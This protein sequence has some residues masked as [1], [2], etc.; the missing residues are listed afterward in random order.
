MRNLN[1]KN[2]LLHLL[3]QGAT[4]ITPNNRLSNTLLQEYFAFSQNKTV[5]KPACYPYRTALIKAFEQLVF[6]NPYQNWPILL[7]K[8][9]CQHLWSKLIKSAPHITYSEGLLN[10]V[11]QAW[12]HCQ[13]WQINPDDPAFLYTPQTR[14]FQLWWQ[15]FNKQLNNSN[16]ISE[17]QILTYLLAADKQLFSRHLV[18]VCFDDFNPL[19]VRLQN[20]LNNHDVI[21][22]CYDLTAQSAT[23]S[24]LAAQDNKDEYQQLMLWL[25]ARLAKGDRRIGVVIPEL[26]QEFCFLQRTL[27]QHFALDL[28]DISLGQ[29][30]SRFPI[31]AHALVWINLDMQQLNHHQATL[32]LQ[33]PYL[34]YAKEEFISRSHHLQDSLLL[35]TQTCS[36]KRFCQDIQ[37]STPKL[38]ELLT[39]LTPYPDS[40]SLQQWIHI[41]QDRL[42]TLG[43]PGDYGLNSENYQCFNRFSTLFDEFRQLTVV[44][45]KLMRNEAIDAFTLLLNNTIFQAQ[46]MSAPIQISGLLEASGCE[47]DSLWVMGLTDQCLPQKPRLSAFI[48][49][50][51]QR[52]LLMPHSLPIRELQF[53]RQTLQRL[54]RA[55]SVT[56]FSYSRLQRDTPNLPCS[57]IACYPDFEPLPV[58]VNL[59]QDSCL[60]TLE[61]SYIVPPKTNERIAGGTAILANQAKCP[62]KAFAKHRLRAEPV[63]SLSDGIDN[64]EKGIIVHKVMELLWQELGSQKKLLDLEAHVLADYIEKA[65]QTALLPLQQHQSDVIPDLVQEVEQT[66]LKRVVQSCLEWEKQRPPF[67][68]A[69]IEHSYSIN[70]AGLDFSVRVDRLDQVEQTKWVI[71]Y[72][73]T[74]PGSKPWNEER[75]QEPQLLLYA[76]L[77]EHIN[78][79]L[80][81]QLKTGKIAC[82]GL[83]E[84]K[85][86]ISG[87]SAL[88]KDETWD[89]SR[90]KWRQQLT[91]LAEEIQAGYCAPQPLSAAICQQCDFQN[92][93]RY[94]VS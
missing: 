73:S 91:L 68:I 85:Q 90:A 52:D 93:C 37:Q 1:N 4:V 45:T 49:P 57:L 61:E 92:L 35:Q 88:K 17:H 22:Y 58:D 79:L 40:A 77:D 26:E 83:S 20:H 50:Q 32:L 34:G 3:A 63:Q 24:V 21:Q 8:T 19:Q 14:Q 38:A 36:L 39:K 23:P 94:Q 6:H 29:P 71:D 54:E 53:A 25:R 69:A 27:P 41:F 56:V 42:N 89:D 51:M 62:F 44:S 30:L 7:N 74:L 78:A 72:K 5:D 13:Q 81:L 55:S 31:I 66:R 60:V 16:A 82:S 76:L 65:I 15:L 2:E 70:L 11:M 64:K 9:Q 33:S 46:K 43:F 86:V 48:P 84:E 87:I 28:F 47:F 67:T 80:L 12:E 18:W 59:E 10:T 75:P